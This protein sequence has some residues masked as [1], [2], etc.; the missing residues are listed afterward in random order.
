[1]IE[2]LDCTI[3]DGSYAVDFTWTPLEIKAITKGLVKCGF[4]YI[5]VGNGIGL[6]ASRKGVKS[7]CTDE[8]YVRYALEVKGL[9][10]KIG[11]FFI[12][13][14]GTLDDIKLFKEYGGNFIRIGMDV[15]RSDLAKDYIQYARELEL[16]VAFNFMKSYAVVPFELCKRAIRIE[17]YG[18]QIISIV[19]SAGGMLPKEVGHYM[20]LLRECVEVRLGFHG[21]NNLLLANANSLSAVE[22]GADI[23]DTTLM[24]LGRGAGNAQTE[25]MLVILKKI[26]LDTGI[27]PI[28]TA[29]ISQQYILPK[30]QSLKGSDD[31]QLVMGDAK[32][33]DAFLDTVI[34]VASTNEIDHRLLIIEVSKINKENPSKDL[35]NSIAK[36]IKLGKTPHVFQPKFYHKEFK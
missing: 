36:H 18:A 15:S 14:I 3:R 8:E 32:F 21:H 31:L 27:N 7:I 24:G 4:K 26:G 13:G 11:V 16:E 33:H 5:E 6:G 10:S 34:E 35:M 29:A 12:P 1:V 28:E 25:T 2:L 17:K 23:I 30:T 22:N 20:K 9:T 19:D